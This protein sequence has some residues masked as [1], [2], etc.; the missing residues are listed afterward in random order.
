M[1][2]IFIFG[3]THQNRAPH[4]TLPLCYPGLHNTQRLLPQDVFFW[5][6]V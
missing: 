2:M 4:H 6:L 1:G 3:K 5:G